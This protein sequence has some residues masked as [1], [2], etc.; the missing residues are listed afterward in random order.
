MGSRMRETTSARP[1]DLP[2]WLAEP[3]AYDPPRDRDAFIARSM[4]AVTSVLAHFRLDDGKATRLS[5]SAPTKLLVGLALILLTSLARNYLFVLVML[6]C[7]LVRVAAL[8]SRKLARV[9]AVAAGAAAL[10][11]VVMLPAILLGQSHSAL[12]VGTKV[13]VSVG[14]AMTVALTTPFNEITAALRVAHVP[15][16]L[17]MTVDLALK[18]IVT[19]GKVALEILTSLRLRSVGRNRDKAASMG[20]VAGVLMLKTKE[21]AD[22]TYASMTCRGFDG[23]YVTRRGGWWRPVDAAWLAALVAVV[24]LF[25]YLQGLM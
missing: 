3:Q 4:L 18:N 10:S 20:G 7:V 22:V 25:V 23:E 5:P 9:S 15:S 14:I 13:L 6:A 21:A 24:A 16:L 19:L 8:P 11:F 17:V 2:A 12:L 1:G